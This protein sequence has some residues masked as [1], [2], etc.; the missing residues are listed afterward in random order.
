MKTIITIFLLSLP[1]CLVAQQRKKG[2]LYL[3]NEA[4]AAY[5]SYHG[6]YPYEVTYQEFIAVPSFSIYESQGISP[7]LHLGVY[8]HL[9]PR[10]AV[11]AGIGNSPV[12]FDTEAG[13]DFKRTL[14]NMYHFSAGYRHLLKSEGKFI[15]YLETEFYF[16]SVSH[17]LSR[18]KGSGSSIQPEIGVI[19]DV[20]N[21]MNIIL[22]G[23]YRYAVSFYH[24]DQLD[25]TLRPYAYGL[26]V[27]V[28]F[29]IGESLEILK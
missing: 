14:I 6:D 29:K 20:S 17:L 9:T 23:Y 11:T 12:H 10:S 3:I 16:Q 8:Y 21:K 1:L 4:G 28:E 26:N 15:P 22:N 25:Y 18:A 19:I 13:F 24:I 27:G 5:T 7:Q 2:D